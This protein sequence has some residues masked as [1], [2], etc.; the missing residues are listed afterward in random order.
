MTR[1]SDISVSYISEAVKTS[2]AF[3]QVVCNGEVQTALGVKDAE[4]AWWFGAWMRRDA[5]SRRL[6][7]WR[8]Y[9]QKQQNAADAAAT[10]T[11]HNE[12]TNE[13]T[14]SKAE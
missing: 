11:D 4:A 1:L 10:R 12:R 5:T 8:I 9:R 3:R 13:R 7:Q 2:D 14:D 6:Y